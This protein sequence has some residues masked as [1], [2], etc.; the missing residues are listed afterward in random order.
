MCAKGDRMR[1]CCE[2]RWTHEVANKARIM[3][4]AIGIG[5]D[6]GNPILFGQS[7]YCEIV[8]D[9]APRIRRHNDRVHFAFA[10]NF[11]FTQTMNA[12][13]AT[14][15]IGTRKASQSGSA[16]ICGRPTMWSMQLKRNFRHFKRFIW[17][18]IAC[19]TVR[20]E[21]WIH[22]PSPV[23]FWS[24]FELLFCSVCFDRST[25]SF[26]SF[27]IHLCLF[28]CARPSCACKRQ[29]Y[30]QKNGHYLFGV[31]LRC[32]RRKNMN[33]KSNAKTIRFCDANCS[34]NVCTAA[35]RCLAFMHAGFFRPPWVTM[36]SVSHSA[37]SANMVCVWFLVGFLSGTVAARTPKTSC[38]PTE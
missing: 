35:V 7:T 6:I 30:I 20:I 1:L 28:M 22:I 25:F 5:I 33:R 3:N 11:T 37:R 10:L 18:R 12:S 34:A 9:Q 38:S 23:S 24:F 17:L 29:L 36:R 32:E 26:R 21:K 8:N 31:W 14:K 4:Y 19:D 2:W 13:A 16:K 27:S 15:W